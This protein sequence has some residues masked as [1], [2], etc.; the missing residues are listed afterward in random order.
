MGIL[1]KFFRL[2]IRKEFLG[3]FFIN[4]L[5]QGIYFDRKTGTIFQK[6]DD[7]KVQILKAH[8]GIPTINGK[9][10]VE[11]VNKEIYFKF[12]LPK[13]NDVYVDIGSGYGHELLYVKNRNQS[14]RIFGIE[15]N[16]IIYNFCKSNC[17]KYRSSLKVFNYMISNTPRHLMRL[18]ADYAGHG[19]DDSGSME[20]EGITLEEF[21]RVNKLET[22][23]FLKLN[24]E[25]AENEIIAN[26]PFDKIKRILVSCHDFRF[27][28]GESEFF[29]T[30][31]VVKKHLINYGYLI[32]EYDTQNA[33]N[34]PWKKS[35]K[36]W[37]Y[38]SKAF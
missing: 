4:F 10:M 26:L 1:K 34:K 24:V 37:I 23:D 5:D 31:D 16:P 29:K 36:Y 8:H 17:F 12:Y 20:V 38:A 6:I 25:G 19:S 11:W 7:C 15:A 33:P 14:V 32:S 18:D 21:M 35:M 13:D 3:N 27:E 28:R 2:L 9:D 30:Y 22:I